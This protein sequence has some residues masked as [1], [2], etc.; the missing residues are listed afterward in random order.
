MLLTHLF[1]IFGRPSGEG[2]RC[3]TRDGFHFTPL[4]LKQD[5]ALMKYKSL[6]PKVA[7]RGN[8]M[9]KQSRITMK[10]S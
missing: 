4:D 2:L 8:T 3:P 9:R 5:T 10:S 7:H 1:N 6:P